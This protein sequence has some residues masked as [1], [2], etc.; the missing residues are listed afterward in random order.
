[1]FFL[2]A[3]V[4][5]AAIIWIYNSENVAVAEVSEKLQRCVL[6][7]DDDDDDDLKNFPAKFLFT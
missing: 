4:A 2:I 5:F 3:F 1:M 7:D 6:Y